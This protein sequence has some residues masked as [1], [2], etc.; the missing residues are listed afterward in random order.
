MVK[1]NAWHAW[2]G[3]APANV[4]TALCKLGTPAA[5]AGCIG[6][7]F[8][9]D[10]VRSVTRATMLSFKLEKYLKIVL[11]WKFNLLLFFFTA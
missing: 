8:D 6:D 5:F 9:G 4:A 3:G 11:H 7:D 1:E 2:P 10:S